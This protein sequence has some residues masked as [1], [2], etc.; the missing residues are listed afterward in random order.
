M[1]YLAN[2]HTV[3][4][5]GAGSVSAA[6]SLFAA[7]LD[8]WPNVDALVGDLIAAGFNDAT[9]DSV[10]SSAGWELAHA[11]LGVMRP[12]VAWVRVAATEKL[13]EED[14][15]KENEAQGSSSDAESDEE[16]PANPPG[17]PAKQPDAKKA[18]PNGPAPLGVFFLCVFCVK[19]R[20]GFFLTQ[21]CVGDHQT[22][23]RL[24]RAKIPSPLVKS[25]LVQFLVFAEGAAASVDEDEL[26]TFRGAQAA[27]G[28][29]HES[30]VA[31]SDGDIFEVRMDAPEVKVFNILGS[32]LLFKEDL[33]RVL[34]VVAP[35]L[36]NLQGDTDQSVEMKK[37]NRQAR[38]KIF[39][40]IAVFFSSGELGWVVF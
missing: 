14:D 34:A 16:T 9:P 36:D 28:R 13:A 21:Q 25:L 12:V 18:R 10:A 31:A 39:L 27:A 30:S 6:A 32:R 20:T 1:L 11:H 33:Q 29:L 38:K 40:S 23:L 24:T 19:F 26:V 7:T 5:T 8:P 35:I 3:F 22:E 15:D 17:G 2:L 37:L 4:S